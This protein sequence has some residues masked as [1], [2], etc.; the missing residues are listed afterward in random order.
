MPPRIALIVLA[1]LAG[2]S[3]GRADAQSGGS[4]AEEEASRPMRLIIEAAKIKPKARP[5][6]TPARPPAV[7][8]RPAVAAAAAPAV[9]VP[10][11]PAAVV[12]AEPPSVSPTSPPLLPQSTVATVEANATPRSP[13][14]APLPAP[15]PEP[16]AQAEPAA[17]PPLK[18]RTLVEPVTP[19]HLAGRLRGEVRVEV[20][21]TVAA[22]G[23]VNEA[24]VMT[25]SHPQMNAAVLDA[26]RQWR[27]EPAGRSREHAVQVVLRP[28]S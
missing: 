28:D 9:A 25:S 13:E 19:R 23:S 4:R 11:E 1:S 3:A 7:S 15:S 20:Q 10:S 14:P 26:V 6:E 24:M 2:L 12:A 22:D 27:Y 18:L 5:V 21:L 17:L 8:V 16:V